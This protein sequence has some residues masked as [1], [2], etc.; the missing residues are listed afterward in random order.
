[1]GDPSSMCVDIFLQICKR[2][3]SHGGGWDDGGWNF[4][5]REGLA[6]FTS[7]T[8]TLL[9]FKFCFQSHQFVRRKNCTIGRLRILIWDPWS[10]C[11][12]PFSKFASEK[13]AMF[14]AAEMMGTHHDEVVGN[15]LLNILAH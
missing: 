15:K 10:M 3:D 5:K 12:N 1:M 2:K 13:T 7:E 8:T 9:E 14:W 11:A 4:A 6:R